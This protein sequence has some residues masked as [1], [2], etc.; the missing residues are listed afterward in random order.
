MG[1]GL[2][3]DMTFEEYRLGGRS[4]YVAFVEAIRN[5]LK[6]AVDANGIVPHA[7]TGRAKDPESL[8]KK[9]LKR[10]VDLAGAVD[11]AVKDLAG[12]RIVFLTNEEIG[13]F[14]GTYLLRENFE[15]ISVN[16]H[17]AVPGTET[18]TKL[19]DSTN[20]LVRL[21]PERL[22]LAEYKPFEGLRAEIQVQTLL[23]HAWAEMGHDTIYKQPDLHN[24]GQK[25][26]E[27]IRD[28]LDRVMREHLLPAGHDFDKIARDFR[29]LLDADGSFEET[30]STLASS[31]DNNEL[32]GAISKLDEL[33]LPQ[34][35]D[36][37]AQFLKLQPA[38]VDAVKRRRGSDA[39][40]LETIFGDYPGKGGDDI[41]RAVSRL[42]DGYLYCDPP[43]TFATLIDL[44]C[45]AASDTERRIWVDLADKFS[46]HDLAIWKEYGPAVPRL[47][48]D[49]I[50]KLSP[51]QRIAARSLLIE[52]L[53]NILSAELG[54]TTW[55]SMS[56]QIHQGA[57]PV[58]EVLNELRTEAITVLEGFLDMAET[59]EARRE[60]L[61]ALRKAAST[62]YN[63]GKP[64]L[65]AMIMSDGARVFAIER[66]RAPDWGLELRRSCEANAIHAHYRLRE[67]PPYLQGA[68]N[69]DAAQKAVVTELLA[70]RDQLNADPDFT[71]YKILVGHDSVRPGA[72][73]EH[74]FDPDGD[75]EWRSAGHD[76]IVARITADTFDEWIERIR[77]YLAEPIFSGGELMSLCDCMKLL[78]ERKPE[79]AA[80][81]LDIMDDALSRLLIGLMLGI[82]ASGAGNIAASAHRWISEGRF[83]GDI[84]EYTRWQAVFDPDML[85]AV[86][87]RAIETGDDDAV[88]TA[89]NAVSSRY[90]KAPEQRLIDEVFMPALGHMETV[91][92]PHWVA[93]AWG[94]HQT[95]LIAALDE[96]Q[97]DRLLRSFVELSEIDYHAD[98][99]L[100]VVATKFPG[101]VIQFFEAR[102]ARG[103]DRSGLRFDPIPFRLNR[104]QKPLSREPVLLLE[105]AR[106]WH[107]D[108]P[109]YHEFRGGRLI[110]HVFPTLSPEMAGLLAELVKTGGR[111]ELDF[112][113]KTLL[114]YEG[115]EAVY[116]LCMDI[117]D[118]LDED[119]EWLSRVSHVLGK[120]GVL[121]GE[122]GF[123]EAEGAQRARL[124][125]WMEDARPKVK[126]YAAQQV[127][128]IDQS[129]A[130]EQR[131]AERDVEQRRRDW[132]EA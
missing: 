57:V 56:V 116:P 54:G 82:D 120:T 98:N 60:I 69:I 15:I 91:Q 132:G 114:A 4:R 129:R 36:R 20:Y 30:V 38:L 5:I 2:G 41:A 43:L 51:E 130:W 37:G 16:V 107:A 55:N 35:D 117:V 94:L 23:N 95:A 101:L 31:D 6:A 73:D 111:V 62:P 32:D 122:F 71:L 106:R 8:R 33:I 75:N 110:G 123:V 1:G 45:G 99:M 27:A 85:I 81:F 12:V 29:R 50:G 119:D 102:V 28:R 78:G 7:I 49:E 68:S 58:S 48:L 42:F 61:G 104:L 131:R 10:E 63:G 115:S 14:N 92:K 11:E 67:L 88:L 97:S 100:A 113:L 52:M 40:P 39:A 46:K 26:L 126:A 64:D 93:N 125:R 53:G 9:L 74:P 87:R 121:T 3:G 83:L 25:R 96:T 18:E 47:V 70:L 34:C 118:C 90:A 103:R 24:V 127:R 19:F 112:I 89:I 80:R 22:A 77:R 72:W 128:Q 13:A 59:D 79:V 76:D 66:T 105:A 108:A 21:R 124:E 65:M 17:H 84:A 44:H 86:T 109:D